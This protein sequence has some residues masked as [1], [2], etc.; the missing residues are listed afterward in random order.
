MNNLLHGIPSASLA[1]LPTPITALTSLAA[2]VGHPALF[3][4]QDNLS[5]PIYGGNKI[6]KLTY[7]LGEAKAQGHKSV[8]TYGAAGSN[9]ALATVIC[10][11]Q[12]GLKAISIL[13]PQATSVHVRKNI[14][15]QQVADAELI[16]CTHYRE[17]PETTARIVQRQLNA[18][19]IEPYII[20]AGGTNVIGALG[21]LEAAFE[22]AEQLTQPSCPLSTPPDIIYLPFGTGG[23]L[24]GLLVG[25]QL[26]GLTQTRVE[27]VRVVDANF[28]NETHVQQLCKDIF[29]LLEYQSKNHAQ[30]ENLLRAFASLRENIHI[31]NEFFGED[32]G[33]STPEAEDAVQT[34]R[35][36]EDIELETTYTGKTLAALLHDIQSGALEGKSVLYWNTLNSRDFS[37]EI[38]HSDYHT[39]PPAFHPYF[40]I[41]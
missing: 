31:R 18:D 22:L 38:Q 28:R 5:G 20:P 6:R 17:F 13:A 12:L 32:Y 26:A 11:K 39:L 21:F 41:S 1:Q 25:L 34:F 4:K 40:E 16:L 9:H 29:T 15:R 30:T 10:A 27:A 24:A 8:I 37:A 23:T 7:L 35:A 2:H 36:L 19:G 3:M 33:I 14:L